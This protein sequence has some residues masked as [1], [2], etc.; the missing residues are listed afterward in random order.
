MQAGIHAL[1]IWNGWPPKTLVLAVFLML[2]KGKSEQKKGTGFCYYPN[3][4]GATFCN[5][6]NPQQY[7]SKHHDDADAAAG[8]NSEAR[9]SLFWLWL[10]L[11]TLPSAPGATSHCF[12]LPLSTST[13]RI[14]KKIRP[15][16]EAI[17]S[18]QI[19]LSEEKQMRRRR[20]SKKIHT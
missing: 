5:F 13:E 20:E 11:S 14:C 3:R 7:T 9:R 1:H 10:L 4:V 18:P 17:Q 19:H 6:P 2:M 15:F 12:E 16:E 8:R